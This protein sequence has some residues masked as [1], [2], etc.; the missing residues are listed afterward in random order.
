MAPCKHCGEAMER[1]LLITLDLPC[2]YEGRWNCPN[3]HITKEREPLRVTEFE[4]SK[5][6]MADD[7][8]NSPY[9]R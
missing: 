2:W 1:L 6:A 3:G 4:R 8:V 5:K 7:S 9:R